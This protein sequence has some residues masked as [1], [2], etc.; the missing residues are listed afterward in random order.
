MPSPGLL[1]LKGADPYS[2]ISK[3]KKKKAKTQTL[4]EEEADK[5][6]NAAPNPEASNQR[7]GS[8][9]ILSDDEAVDLLKDPDAGS[10]TLEKIGKDD[11][12]DEDED[13][14]PA[15]G[16]TEAEIRHAER[17]RQRVRFSFLSSVSAFVPLCCP[18]LLKSTHIPSSST[19]SFS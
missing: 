11:K 15:A 17:R 13:T 18:S 14:N 19:T 2:K 7:D 12:E 3:P 4:V 16:K 8:G 1:R 10:K 9:Q 6:T 5:D